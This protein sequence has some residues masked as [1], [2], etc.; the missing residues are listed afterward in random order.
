[1][2]FHAND[3]IYQRIYK[4][5]NVF[6]N[7]KAYVHPAEFEIDLFGENEDIMLHTAGRSSMA[8]KKK[9][10]EEEE[11]EGCLVLFEPEHNSKGAVHVLNPS[12][13]HIK[14]PFK[15][16]EGED[17]EAFL[18]FLIIKKEPN[19]LVELRVNHDYGITVY[20]DVIN[21]VK[22]VA[23]KECFDS[24]VQATTHGIMTGEVGV[25]TPLSEKDDG[26]FMHGGII[27]SSYEG[28]IILPCTVSK[29]DLR[30][31]FKEG[32]LI[33]IMKVYDYYHLDNKSHDIT[34]M[35][36]KLAGVDET[37]LRKRGT[38]GFGSSG[39]DGQQTVEWSKC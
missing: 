21:K 4:P 10:R 18:Q 26:F 14:T 22:T 28:D 30:R 37:T 8:I 29:C 27:D 39:A 33:A 5:I 16:P 20:E 12:K 6:P 38:N 23:V 1:M 24:I 19:R 17:F 25:I 36:T 31:S 9:K 35:K 7:I 11:D 32:D 34:H 13:E 2:T 3:E 15:I